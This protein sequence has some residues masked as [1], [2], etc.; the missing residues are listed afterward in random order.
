MAISVHTNG[1]EIWS[2]TKKQEAKIETAEMKFFRS[3]AGYA[4]KDQ[5]INTKIGEALNV[6]NLSNRTLKYRS[7]WKYHVLRMQDRR[8][9]KKILT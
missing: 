5:T 3:V 6:L 2:I 8:I 7:H 9:P 4:R 1:S